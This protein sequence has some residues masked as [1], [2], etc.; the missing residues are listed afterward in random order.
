MSMVEARYRE[1]AAK[2]HP[3]RTGNGDAMVELNA[4]RDQAREHYK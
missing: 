1:L 2:R 4:A 3:D